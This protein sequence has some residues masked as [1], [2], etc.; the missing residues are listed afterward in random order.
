MGSLSWSRRDDGGMKNISSP[1][2]LLSRW[3]RFGLFRVRGVEAV[4]HLCQSLLYT[5][6]TLSCMNFG[7]ALNYLASFLGSTSVSASPTVL[8]DQ[9]LLRFWSSSKHQLSR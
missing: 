4:D 3:K 7:E 5:T 2:A 8:N 9:Q 1:Y 6:N